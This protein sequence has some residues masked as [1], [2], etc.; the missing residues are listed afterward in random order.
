MNNSEKIFLLIDAN[1]IFHRAYHALPRFKTKKGELTNAVYGFSSILIKA[2]K[3]LKPAYVAAAF[4][5]EGPTFRDEEYED[6]KATRQKAPDELYEQIP[7]I[8]EV[9]TAFNVPVYE[10]QGF[11]ADDIIGTVSKLVEQ[12]KEDIKIIIA[13]GDL[14]TLQLVS[15]HTRVYTM[16]KSVQDTV[17]Y[18]EE[19]VK[20]RFGLRP[21]QMVDYKGLRGDPSDNIVGVPGVGEKTAAVLLKKYGNL[22]DMYRSV[23]VEKP[24]IISER[25]WIILKENKEQALFSRMLATIRRDVKLNFKLSDA[26][27]GGFDPE[28]ARQLFQE[29]EFN[30]LL[31]GLNELEGFKSIEPDSASNGLS[32]EKDILREVDSA[33]EAGILSDEIYN[34]EKELIPVLLKMEQKGIKIDKDKLS[35]LSKKLKKKLQDIERKIYK[36]AGIKFNINSSQQLSDILFE[37]LK[38]DP[39]GLRKTPGKKISIAA[40]E[41]EKLRGQHPIVDLIFEQR[42]I[43]KLLSTYVVP[44]PKLAD[45]NSRIHT[46]FNSL[47]ASTGR[48]SSKDPNLQNI[49]IRG[50]FAEDIRSSFIPE[51][52]KKFMACDYSQMELRVIAHLAQDKNMIDV[53]RRDEDVHAHTAALV[54]GIKEKDVTPKMRYRAKAL[55]F[56]IIYGIGPKAFS[57]SAEISFDE[58]KKFIQ[59]YMEIFQNIARYM[60]ETKRRAHELG[61]V[62]TL[63]GRKRFISDLSSPNPMLRAMAER[64][65]I[66]MPVQGTAAD[67]VK[68]AMVKADKE[69][70]GVDLLLQIHDELLWEGPDDK[71]KENISKAKDILEN[72]ASLSVPLKVDCKVGDNWGNLK[73]DE[74]R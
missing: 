6:Y 62:E 34:L 23:E 67:I 20:A 69:L 3:E 52:G 8:K 4:D 47:G 9:L 74:S 22:D 11:E 63:F 19:A 37:R 36:K 44:L 2:L 73:S 59:R 21:E 53:F 33:R 41:L 25:I 13:S 12:K 46:V 15:A 40:S 49:P 7:R 1:S 26:E 5:V 55:N 68:M 17:L 18:N 66:N 71:I 45:E 10:K 50:E 58:A 61:Y 32:R 72:A 35:A 39:K 30:R 51:E 24:D 65:A 29:L 16:K 38:I 14:D 57:E 31:S 43:Q 42:E 27:W 48:I 28:K 60:E 54:F 56:G 64:A 70:R